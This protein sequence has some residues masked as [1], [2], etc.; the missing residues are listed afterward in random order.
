MKYESVLEMIGDT[1]IV[2]LNSF[3]TD[4]I[5]I[6]AKLEKFNIGGSV[7][8]RIGLS[9]I[10]HAE[11]TGELT[12]DKTILE[13]TS[14]NTGIGLVLVGKS[15]GYKVKF[16]MPESM[17]MER[18][19]MLKI[20]GAELVLTPGAEGMD[21]TIRKAREMVKDPQYFMPSQ[22]ENEWNWRAH[23]KTAEEIWKD[24][25]GKVTHVVMGMGTTG[26][27]VG[28]SKKMREINP[29]VKIVAIEPESTHKIQGL[30]SLQDSITPG[31]FDPNAYDQ[32]LIVSTDNAYE[33]ARR[34][35]KEEQ[36]FMGMSSGAALW[37]ALQ[38]AKEIEEGLIVVIFPDGGEKYLSTPLFKE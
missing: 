31:I 10:E 34:L 4:K 28:I 21:G 37:G 27:L 36:L 12:K 6:Y 20:Y 29:N 15:K 23:F 38:V 14:G 18:R 2:K 19:Q 32:K 17:S 30:K 25:E 24:T 1:P 33:M 26:T 13:P 8:D 16:T 5:K 35:P 11:E 9:M 3:S 22:F 7:K